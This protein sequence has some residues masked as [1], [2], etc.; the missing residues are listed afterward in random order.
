MTSNEESGC[1]KLPWM[2]EFHSTIDGKILNYQFD[3]AYADDHIEHLCRLNVDSLLPTWRLC[4]IMCSIGP[5]CNDPEVLLNMMKAGMTM[6]YI[7]MAHTTLDGVKDTLKNIKIAQNRYCKA[8]KRAVSIGIGIEIKGPE[9]R[10]GIIEDPDVK[11]IELKE[12]DE[13]SL[14][15][16][17][18]YEQFVS[19]DMIYVNYDKLTQVVEPGDKILISDSENGSVTLSAIEIVG[20]IIR[21]LIENAGTIAN[22]ASVS[23]EAA[24]DLP[25]LSEEDEEVLQFAAKERIS[26]IF[27][28]YAERADILTQ[29]RNTLG[30]NGKATM[31]ISKIENLAG[32]Y[33][34]DE[35]IP[36]SDGVLVS[37]CALGREIPFEKMILVQKMIVGKC[38]K[39]GL[40]VIIAPHMLQSMVK[41]PTPTNAE[42]S[43]ITS[44]IADGVDAF[45]LTKET[46]IG[47]YPVESVDKLNVICR[48][49]EPLVYQK[50]LFGDLTKTVSP[51]EPIYAIAIAA[52][53][54]SLKVNA[55]G[56]VV[57]SVTGR[58]AKLISRFRPRCPIITV[59]RHG[60]VAR[61]LNLWRGVF[62]IQYIKRYDEDWCKDIE[63]RVQYGLTYGKLAGYVRT[64]DAVVLITGSRTGAGFTNSLKI[65]YASEY[66]CPN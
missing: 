14:T 55:A 27:I 51:I 43:D 15:T 18:M 36:A 32:I 28:P 23:L 50:Q 65:V 12:G 46:A 41:Q 31:I 11:D 45:A 10:T 4:G 5:S 58:S 20:S 57:T 8:Q 30:D 34:I 24:I 21:C 13:T 62:P 61:F 44:C 40:P 19:K 2:V 22:N 38:N 64:G 26:Y 39:N 3:A 60:H 52:V 17:P 49:A 56:I 29:V 54:A 66:D 63:R 1:P 7:K 9:I 53:E 25:L 33:N 59:T 35:L 47:P 16:D 6:A 37:R 48:H 42:L